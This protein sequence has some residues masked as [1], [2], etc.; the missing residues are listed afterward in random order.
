MIIAVEQNVSGV[1]IFA[2]LRKKQANARVKTGIIICRAIDI[3]LRK[4]FVSEQSTPESSSSI[5][6]SYS[7]S[8]IGKLT[9][10]FFSL[11]VLFFYCSFLFISIDRLIAIML[12]LCI[13]QQGLVQGFDDFFIWWWRAVVGS[14]VARWFFRTASDIFIQRESRV[15]I[16]YLFFRMWVYR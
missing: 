6:E 16:L 14:M 4:I 13:C 9:A 2:R 5:E 3:Y 12:T 1:F 10:G 11:D 15:C 7:K 8:L